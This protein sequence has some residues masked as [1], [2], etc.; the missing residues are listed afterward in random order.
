ML[1]NGNLCKFTLYGTVQ[2]FCVPRY[3]VLKGGSNVGLG[4]FCAGHFNFFSWALLSLPPP[5]PARTSDR[6]STS[7]CRLARSAGPNRMA[8]LFRLCQ[9]YNAKNSMAGSG[10]PPT[11]EGRASPTRLAF[12]KDRAAVR[13][14]QG[15]GREAWREH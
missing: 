3:H 13:Y 6:S 15:R 14:C 11:G 4:S 12:W 9:P 2:Y 8:K 5:R 1:F 10:T 7:R